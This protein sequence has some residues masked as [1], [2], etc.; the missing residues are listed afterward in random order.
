MY[1]EYIVWRVIILGVGGAMLL[2][3]GGRAC[4][5]QAPSRKERLLALSVVDR[6]VVDY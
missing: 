5:P 6:F 1:T 3:V 4:A 2:L